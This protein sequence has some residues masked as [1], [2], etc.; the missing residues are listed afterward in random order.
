MVTAQADVIELAPTTQR[1]EAVCIGVDQLSRL[2]EAQVEAGQLNDAA[3]TLEQAR[4]LLASLNDSTFQTM[5][6]QLAHVRMLRA[7]LQLAKANQDV[8]LQRVKIEQLVAANRKL[9][10]DFPEGE[11]QMKALVQALCDQVE[12][13]IAQGQREPARALLPEIASLLD[14]IDGNKAVSAWAVP[15]RERCERLREQLGD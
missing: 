15:L 6:V 5:E 9:S 2:V 12:F 3:P 11:N 1:T 13:A 10:R 8:G 14:R 7:E 4:T